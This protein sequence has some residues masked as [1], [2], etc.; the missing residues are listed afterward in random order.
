MGI[1]LEDIV[2]I[3]GITTF[4]L[5]AVLIL[6]II[7]RAEEKVLGG[8]RGWYLLALT[9]ILLGIRAFGHFVEEYWFQVL[10]RSIGIAVSV[11]YPLSLHLIYK[12]AMGEKH[13]P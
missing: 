4:N 12:E 11:L 3:A 13:G 9:C 8:K 7:W 2:D 1:S 6:L 5:S 10:R